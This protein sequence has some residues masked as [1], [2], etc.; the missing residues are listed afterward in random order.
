MHTFARTHA[1]ARRYQ[2]VDRIFEEAPRRFSSGTPGRMGYEDF[3]WF[4]LSEEDKTTDT[5]AEYWFRCADLDCDGSGD[6]VDCKLDV[7]RDGPGL[8]CPSHPSHP[9][10]ATPRQQE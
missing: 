5:A 6:D 3:V 9:S 8:G 7:L 4:I 10:W 1:P 2:I